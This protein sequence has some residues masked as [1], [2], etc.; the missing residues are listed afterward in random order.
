MITPVW[1]LLQVWVPIVNGWLRL[2]TSFQCH[3]FLDLFNGKILIPII[4]HV[5][6]F[7]RCFESVKVDLLGLCHAT[8]AVL[9]FFIENGCYSVWFFPVQSTSVL[10]YLSYGFSFRFLRSL[11]HNCFGSSDFNFWLRVLFF[12]L[13][14]NFCS[15]FQC[16]FKCEDPSLLFLPTLWLLLNLNRL[17]WYL[18][19]P[20]LSVW[21][22]SI[23]FRRWISTLDRWNNTKVSISID[24]IH[25]G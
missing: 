8:Y 1:F 18:L 22:S 11:L 6:Q 25:I 23:R 10:G 14:L 13:F 24:L 12:K 21:R 2:E 17:F 9:N 15:I 19:H 4:K 3:G 20:L 5:L 16:L 7:L